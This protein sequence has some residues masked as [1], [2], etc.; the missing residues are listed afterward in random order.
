MSNRMI[1]PNDTIAALLRVADE[2]AWAVITA[3][4]EARKYHVACLHSDAYVEIPKHLFREL[5]RALTEFFG[6][7]P[8]T[9]KDGAR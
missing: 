6:A 7:D 8:V 4:N 5:D 9:P 1:Y 2:R 3:A